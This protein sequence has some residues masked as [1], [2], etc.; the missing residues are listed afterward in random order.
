VGGEKLL[1]AVSIYDAERMSVNRQFL[2]PELG[3]GFA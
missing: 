1:P 3:F 2:E